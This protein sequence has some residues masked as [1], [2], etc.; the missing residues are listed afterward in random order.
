MFHTLKTLWILILRRVKSH[1]KDNFKNKK[2]VDI[3]TGNGWIGQQLS[4]YR[5]EVI[6]ELLF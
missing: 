3:P 5:I 2:V 6:S 4:E 1:F